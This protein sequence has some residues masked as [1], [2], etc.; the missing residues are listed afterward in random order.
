MNSLLIC[1]LFAF[2]YCIC[3]FFES[4]GSGFS[5]VSR[6]RYHRLVATIPGDCLMTPQGIATFCDWALLMPC[7]YGNI[8]IKPK[9]VFVHHL[10]LPRFIASVLPTI[11]NR[12]VLVTSGTDQTIPTSRG[13]MRFK[14]MAGF[15]NQDDGGPSWKLL[16]TH[17]MIMH[18]YC[19]NHDLVHPKVSTLPIGVVEGT[20]GMEHVSIIEHPAIPLSKRPVKFLVAHRLRTATGQWGYRA[21]ITALCDAQIHLYGPNASSCV[22]PPLGISKGPRKTIPQADYIALAENASFIACV[23]GGGIDPS[24]KAWEAIMLGTIPIIQHSTL[25]DAYSQLPVVFVDHWESLFADPVKVQMRLLQARVKLEAYYTKPV[26]RALV[27][28]VCT[29]SFEKLHLK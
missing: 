22:A 15:A 12:F 29:V 14:P 16:T 3:I 5:N 4:Y 23:R 28:E 9:T 11:H 26:M 19:E 18:W 25:D 6:S 8:S 1:V 17:P 10:M 2:I 7:F 13:D 27:L 21:N 20:L 24:P